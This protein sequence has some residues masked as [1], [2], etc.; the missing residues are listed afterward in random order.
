MTPQLGPG[1]LRA[2]A[3]TVDR[4]ALAAPER[5]MPA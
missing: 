5:P 4:E 1:D 2:I 3:R